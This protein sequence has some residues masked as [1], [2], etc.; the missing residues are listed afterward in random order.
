MIRAKLRCGLN[1]PGGKNIG[2]GYIGAGG[3]GGYI[4]CC[5][6]GP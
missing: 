3:G 5:G 2:G 1:I 6:G 4:C